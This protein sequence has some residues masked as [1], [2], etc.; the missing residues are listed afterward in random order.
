MTNEIIKTK[1]KRGRPKRP[2][3]DEIS[4]EIDENQN[5]KKNKTEKV[6]ESIEQLRLF[7]ERFKETIKTGIDLFHNR[8]SLS[9]IS[10][11]ERLA[12]MIILKKIMSSLEWN[13]KRLISNKQQ[14]ECLTRK[15]IES[16]KERKDMLKIME[17]FVEYKLKSFPGKSRTFRAASVA[18]HYQCELKCYGVTQEMLSTKIKELIKTIEV[19]EGPLPKFEKS[20]KQ[21]FRILKRNVCR[22][23]GSKQNLIYSINQRKD[24]VRF[25]E[26]V[27]YFCRVD[28]NDNDSLPHLVC[29]ACK[30]HIENFSKFSE[31]IRTFQNK[32]NSDLDNFVMPKVIKTEIEDLD[33]EVEV[34]TSSCNINNISSEYINESS[35]DCTDYIENDIEVGANYVCSNVNL[36]V[37]NIP[38]SC[39]AHDEVPEIENEIILN[40]S[41]E[42]AHNCDNEMTIDSSNFEVTT[43]TPKNLSPPESSRNGPKECK[44]V[45]E[46]LPIQYVSSD[47]EESQDDLAEE[48]KKSKKRKTCST[49]QKSL[50]CLKINFQTIQSS[51]SALTELNR[52]ILL[53]IQTEDS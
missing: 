22:L 14:M 52:G 25:K 40:T 46:R 2:R 15:A 50:P 17:E 24:D 49:Q 19:T 35:Q 6:D 4:G 53:D 32:L 1:T 12:Y 8:I 51:M 5:A 43:S 20:P 38:N 18:K 11:K 31:Q 41:V 44:V 34:V 28:I 23:C 30:V 36:L 29:K 47:V 10:F 37:P 48:V 16:S 39:E 45:L 9:A 42:E 3:V 21:C 7:E 26:V 13:L 27:E 33:F